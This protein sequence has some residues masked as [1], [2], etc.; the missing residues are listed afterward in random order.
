MRAIRARQIDR[1]EP[2]QMPENMILLL[3]LVPDIL[4]TQVRAYAFE[5]NQIIPGK[6]AFRVVP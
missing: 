5:A 1:I 2:Q 3:D 6:L 4:A